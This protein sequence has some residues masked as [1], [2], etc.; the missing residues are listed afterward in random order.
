MI[1]EIISVSCEDCSGAG[2]I[3]WGNDEDFDVMPCDCANDG[4]LFWNGENN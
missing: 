1:K 4:S 2:F 3:F